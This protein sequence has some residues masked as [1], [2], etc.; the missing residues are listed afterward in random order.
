[1]EAGQGAA[2]GEAGKKTPAKVSAA[3]VAKLAMLEFTKDQEKAIEKDLDGMI[4]FA[5]RLSELN[6]DGVA[7]IPLET[8]SPLAVD[9]Y[10]PLALSVSI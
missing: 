8:Y 4:A 5:D 9:A 10:A 1:M 6:A 2:S 7:A 3:R